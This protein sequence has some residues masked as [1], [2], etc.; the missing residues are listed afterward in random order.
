MP[1]AGAAQQPEGAELPAGNGTS[2]CGSGTG[3]T[4]TSGGTGGIGGTGSTTGGIGGSM[5]AT[6]S[7]V[8]VG[9]LGAA[10][11]VTVAAGA[12]VLF[13]LRGR[14]DTQA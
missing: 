10:A 3:G 11:A 8:P 6:G 12:G 9:A 14:R 5:A 13:A 4:G 1:A 2:G 7:D